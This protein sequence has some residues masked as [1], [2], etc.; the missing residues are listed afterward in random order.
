[1]HKAARE[2]SPAAAPAAAPA[3]DLTG[4]VTSKDFEAFKNQFMNE[5]KAQLPALQKLDKLDNLQQGQTGVGVDLKAELESFRKNV[6]ADVKEAA[7][8]IKKIAKDKIN[9]EK[10]RI[11]QD[12]NLSEAEMKAR[13]AFLDAQER[14]INQ[15]F[16]TVGRQVES[17]DGD[18]MDKA[19]L[20]SNL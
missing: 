14:A 17:A 20:L 2:A 4:L 9:A 11:M 19:D 13:L 7:D 10:L 8:D 16:E 1:V 12:N 5:L 15:N 6:A 3:P 18:V